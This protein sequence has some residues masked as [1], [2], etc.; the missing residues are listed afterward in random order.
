MQDKSNFGLNSKN[1]ILSNRESPFLPLPALSAGCTCS[2]IPAD[3]VDVCA[4]LHGRLTGKL[5]RVAI[6]E[7]SPLGPVPKAWN[8]PACDRIS[9]DNIDVNMASMLWTPFPL[10]SAA[11][12]SQNRKAPRTLQRAKQFP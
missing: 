12:I 11:E 5:G 8:H 3:L 6:I 7:L 9:L 4:N 2:V 1:I 10:I